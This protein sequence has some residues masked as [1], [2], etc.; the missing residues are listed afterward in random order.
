MH[1]RVPK[2][3][4]P[5]LRLL[6]GFLIASVLLFATAAAISIAF[7][8]ES[9]TIRYKFGLDRQ[10]LRTGQM[11]GIV[12]GLLLL[13]QIILSARL[14]CLDRI[15][16]MSSLLRFH[17]ITG[18]IIA[19][20]VCLHPILIFIP[21][22]R[23]S[24]PLQ[25][26]YWP[27]FVG[28][29]LALL[30]IFTLISSY[31]RA[32]L[33]LAFHRWRPIHQVAAILTI[34]AFYI[35]LL[36][37]SET[38]AQQLPKLLAF[39]TMGLWGL[40]FLWIRSRPRRSRRKAYMVSAIEPA[41]TNA[42][43]LKIIARSHRIPAYMPGQFSFLTFLSPHLP[44]EEHPFTIA[45]TPSKPGHLEFI[46][47]TTGDWTSQLEKLQPRDRVLMN[48][49]F[50]MFTHLRLYENKELIFIA[51]G[52]GITPMLSMLRCMA[53]HNDQRKITLIW[54]NQTRQHIIFPHEFRKLEVQLKGLR[55]LH[56]LTRD[57]ELS[58]EKGR[59]DRVKLKMLM[60]ECSISSAV[61]IC[62]PNRMMKAVLNALLALG[63]SR[64]MIYLERFAL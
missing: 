6:F 2:I 34:T 7:Y 9:A 52:I 43:C 59:L 56:V 60:S 19:V 36:S 41:G 16:G 14:K 54:S 12:A 42:L 55:I 28:L 10:L 45:S 44:R 29:F 17:R 21:E 50:G 18:A 38:F 31:W 11:L 4:S 49:P 62:G 57:S 23:I 61:F 13:L 46:V 47:R 35:H 64:R 63:F 37:V 22:G 32:R 1:D 33:R 25:L 30:V 5:R 27:E 40:F 48:G 3:L 51:G 53:D 15:F 20:L 8:F 39:C 24:I 58:G 26:R